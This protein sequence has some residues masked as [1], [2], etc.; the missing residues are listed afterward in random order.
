MGSAHALR[1]GV[2]RQEACLNKLGSASAFINFCAI[3]YNYCIAQY[4]HTAT[5]DF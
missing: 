4:I 3:G 2:G 1:W 5:H